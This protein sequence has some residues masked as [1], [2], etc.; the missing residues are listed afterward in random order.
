MAARWEPPHSRV[1]HNAKWDL[2]SV[3]IHY[4]NRSIENDYLILKHEE[5][6]PK[7]LMEERK[8]GDTRTLDGKTWREG[9][10]KRGCRVK[11]E[12]PRHMRV[13]KLPTRGMRVT[14]TYKRGNLK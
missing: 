6:V 9:T 14:P 2:L 5:R 7:E 4:K 10:I 1:Y 3:R 12:Q 8:W 11:K 13:T